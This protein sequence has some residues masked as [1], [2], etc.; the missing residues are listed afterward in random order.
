M[1]VAETHRQGPAVESG[2]DYSRRRIW[3]VLSGVLLGMLLAALDQTVV[4][5]AMPR[6]IAE[7]RG[8]EHYAWVFTAYML[9]STVTVPIYGKLSDI[10]GRRVFFLFGMVVFLLGSALSGLSQSMTQLVVFRAVQG[11]GAGAL[12][13]IALAIVGDLLPPAERGKWQGVFAAV[14]GLTSIVGPTLGG[15]ITDHWGWRWVFYVNM[16]VGAVALVAA[17]L[18]IPGRSTR[19][20]HTI[21]YAGAAALVAGTVPLLLALSWAG[22]EYP[23]GSIQIVGLLAFAAVMLTA[24]FLLELRAVEP[25]VDPR[26]FKHRIYALS[27]LAGFFIAVGMFGTILYLPLFIQGVLGRTATNSGAV[28][29]PMMLGFVASSVIGG[30]LMA[31]TGRYKVLA[32]GSVALAALGMLLLSRMTPNT[33][34]GEVVRNMVITGLGIGTTM[35]LFTIVVQ[36]AF[37]P[38]VLG[39][40]TSGL[41]FF[42]SIGGTLG[43]AILGS[44]LTNRFSSAFSANLPPSVAQHLGSSQLAALRDPQALVSPEAL[45]R[46]QDAFAQLGPAGQ[47]LFAEVM[48]ALRVSLSSAI[49]ELFAVGAVFMV[50]ALLATALIPEIPLRRTTRVAT[51]AAM[52]EAPVA[53][54][55]SVA[56]RGAGLDE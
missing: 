17:G 27:V 45:T 21:D 55:A 33:G 43:A 24:F 1:T 16:P 32:I 39:E 6:I 52:G 51:Q 56:E 5:T 36:N 30:Q 11:L 14:W 28:L 7:L 15:W 22:T 12:F 3:L 18:T 26:L 8:L 2:H 35:S 13:P 41:V 53:A 49:T 38:N 37:P 20:Q 46:M 42:R 40:V 10:Y 19:R 50:L 47:Q 54:P 34:N 29:T 23:W 9:A 31:R 48:S 25:I 44:V 4:G